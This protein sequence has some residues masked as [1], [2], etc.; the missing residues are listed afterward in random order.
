MGERDA[1]PCNLLH[2][3]IRFLQAQVKGQCFQQK[4]P[5]VAITGK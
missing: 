2:S 3:H 1:K 5:S 4:R